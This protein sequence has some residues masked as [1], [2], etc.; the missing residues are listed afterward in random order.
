MAGFLFCRRN[1]WGG[2]RGYLFVAVSVF[3]NKRP[4][5]GGLFVINNYYLTVVVALRFHFQT[6]SPEP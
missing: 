6:S 4:A 3:H 2:T 1:T 5:I